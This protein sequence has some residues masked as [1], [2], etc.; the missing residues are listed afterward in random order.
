MES[1]AQDN[2]N[3]HEE[4]KEVLETAIEQVAQLD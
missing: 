1:N 2:K 3:V 4:V